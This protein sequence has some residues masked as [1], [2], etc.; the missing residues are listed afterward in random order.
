MSELV[1]RKYFFFLSLLV[2]LVSDTSDYISPSSQAADHEVT[3][4]LRPSPGL[5]KLA[6][7]KKCYL[8]LQTSSP[9]MSPHGHSCFVANPPVT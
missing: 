9:T 8:Q 5:N 4:D 6:A 2:R 1:V 3:G 7:I